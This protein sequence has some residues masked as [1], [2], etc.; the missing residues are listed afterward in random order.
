MLL[1]DSTTHI[2][3]FVLLKKREYV[4]KTHNRVHCP[5]SRVYFAQC[6]IERQ[7]QG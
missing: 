3:K 2:A 7:E 4:T 6:G 1:L 5:G